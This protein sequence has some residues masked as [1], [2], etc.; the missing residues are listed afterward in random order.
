MAI[1]SETIRNS[2]RVSAH[3]AK[4]KIAEVEDHISFPPTEIELEQFDPTP[5]IHLQRHLRITVHR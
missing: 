3:V 2:T 5:T 4:I 1:L